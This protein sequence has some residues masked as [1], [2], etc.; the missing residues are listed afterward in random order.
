LITTFS[1]LDSNT[2]AQAATGLTSNSVGAG[3]AAELIDVQVL[4]AVVATPSVST[5][6]SSSTQ[7]GW[8]LSAV[9][10]VVGAVAM[11]ALAMYGPNLPSIGSR[12]Q[13]EPIA[14]AV[15]TAEPEVTSSESAEFTTAAAPP[16]AHA[17]PI[18]EPVVHRTTNETVDDTHRPFVHHAAPAASAPP[19]MSREAAEPVTS[20]TQAL[21]SHARSETQP[22]KHR[23]RPPAVAVAAQ[24]L[25]QP[26]TQ[27]ATP[28]DN[29]LPEHPAEALAQGLSG[30]VILRLHIDAA[31]RVRRVDIHQSSG[32]AILDRAAYATALNRWRFRPARAG[33]RPVAQTIRV[34]VVFL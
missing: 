27:H 25:S 33:S 2:L 13:S 14:L 24:Q 3:A 12:N 23:A 8:L 11:V 19:M 21:A 1:H 32:H 6:L 16:I 30:K 20:A 10:H 34:P 22:H 4:P 5:V 17:Q 7:L 15:R 31:G 9:T 26:I 28:Y 29:P 18:V